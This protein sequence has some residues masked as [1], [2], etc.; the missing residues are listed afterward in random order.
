MAEKYYYCGIKTNWFSRE[1]IWIWIIENLFLI[2]KPKRSL[3]NNIDKCSLH[4]KMVKS[5]NKLL[6]CSLLIVVCQMTKKEGLKNIKLRKVF[7]P[8]IPCPLPL[9]TFPIH[10]YLLWVSNIQIVRRLWA[11]PLRQFDHALEG[12]VILMKTKRQKVIS[13]PR[14]CQRSYLR[15]LWG[16]R[17]RIAV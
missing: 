5:H 4:F 11:K 14:G 9:K 10:L 12:C 8:Q 17:D 15:K 16:R 6:R 1:L 2:S 3:S 13:I 7:F